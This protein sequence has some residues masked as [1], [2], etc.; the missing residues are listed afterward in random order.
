[1]G[2]MHGVGEEGEIPKEK[3]SLKTDI[4]LVVTAASVAY[5]LQSVRFNVALP[6]LAQHAPIGSNLAQHHHAV[7][8]TSDL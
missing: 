3:K 7:H 2:K 5:T 4:G 8:A 1:M 6:M